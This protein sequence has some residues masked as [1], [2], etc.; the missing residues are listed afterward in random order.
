MA[1]KDE[2]NFS[3]G[4]CP[5]LQTRRPQSPSL[6]ARVIF[7]LPF[8]GKGESSMCW[9]IVRVACTSISLLLNTVSPDPFACAHQVMEVAWS[10]HQ[11][12][13]SLNLLPHCQSW[14]KKGMNEPRNNSC[15]GRISRLQSG[16]QVGKRWGLFIFLQV[17][18]FL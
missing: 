16:S 10:L 15:P 11:L 6:C 13:P 9:C 7:H 5:G 4:H 14:T 1:F 3:S 8:N 17:F 18:S 12:H 2:L